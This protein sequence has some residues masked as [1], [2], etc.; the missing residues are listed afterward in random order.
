M[1]RRLVSERDPQVSKSSGFRAI[2]G[3]VFFGD[4][5]HHE[6]CIWLLS[7]QLRRCAFR[8][9]SMRS[10]KNEELAQVGG[11]RGGGGAGGDRGQGTSSSASNGNPGTSNSA[12]N[13]N[14]GTS[15][16]NSNRARP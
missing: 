3:H 15:T 13:G 1:V 6:S 9:R 4:G 14:P 5:Q 12:G 10:L 16:S 7:A 8:R 11:G 2:P